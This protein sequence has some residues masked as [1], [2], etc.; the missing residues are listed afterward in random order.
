MIN[1]QRI[2]ELRTL[3]TEVFGDRIHP[4]ETNDHP[5]GEDATRGPHVLVDFEH[6]IWCEQI[7]VVRPSIAPRPPKVVDGYIVED[8]EPRNGPHGGDP[9][10]E[11]E[12]ETWEAALLD[13]FG[14]LTKSAVEGFLDRKADQEEAERWAEEQRGGN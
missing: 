6:G 1:E 10:N 3:L 14:R 13:L 4:I 5:N 2:A 8:Y 11:V 7:E 9:I 12:H